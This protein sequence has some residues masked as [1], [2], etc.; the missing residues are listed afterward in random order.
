MG[1]RLWT[2]QI[3]LPERWQQLGPEERQQIDLEAAGYLEGWA[4][5]LRAE[6]GQIGARPA[7]AAGLRRAR[8][9]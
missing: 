5:R 3:G 8:F 4:A 9:G 1:P 7:P 2:F 6:A